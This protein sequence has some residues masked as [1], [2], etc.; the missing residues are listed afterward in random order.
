MANDDAATQL[1]LFRRRRVDAEQRAPQR[2][3]G[4]TAE[5]GARSAPGT[6]SGGEVEVPSDATVSGPWRGAA[7]ALGWK[8]V[9]E[10][11]A[12][13]PRHGEGALVADERELS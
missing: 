8:D 13:G 12:V 6:P 11:R 4:L 7:Q 3:N 2:R 9:K 1:Q 10:L 5:S